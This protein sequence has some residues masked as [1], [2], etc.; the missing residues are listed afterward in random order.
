MAIRP[1]LVDSKFHTSPWNSR[2]RSQRK[3]VKAM[4]KVNFIGHIRGLDFNRYVCFLVFIRN[5]WNKHQNKRLV[6]AETVHRSSTYIIL[7]IFNSVITR[8]AFICHKW[9]KKT[10]Y[11]ATQ[12]W[13]ISN[14]SGNEPLPE[15]ILTYLQWGAPWHSPEFNFTYS[16]QGIN[17]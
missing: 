11:M 1:F 4:A 6:S 9:I 5:S 8:P 3:K 10:S 17:F 13:W 7:Y 2:S 15:I 16:A 14:G 12:H